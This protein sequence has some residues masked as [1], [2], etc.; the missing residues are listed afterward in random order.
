[1]YFQSSSGNIENMAIRQ[2]AQMVSSIVQVL[3]ELPDLSLEEISNLTNKI[4]E[5]QDKSVEKL[6]YK[7]IPFYLSREGSF[8]EWSACVDWYGRLMDVEL[9]GMQWPTRENVIVSTH[10]LINILTDIRD[11][12]VIYPDS[13]FIDK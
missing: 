1:M 6:I 13:Y 12:G 8:D 4:E 7:G 11:T 3:E 9:E 10:R 2:F 5:S